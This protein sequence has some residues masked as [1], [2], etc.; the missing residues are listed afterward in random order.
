MTRRLCFKTPTSALSD[1]CLGLGG[2]L[3]YW[4]N[5]LFKYKRHSYGSSC[6]FYLEVHVVIRTQS[7]FAL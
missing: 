2:S 4:N 5:E 1:H 6:R 7:N 3:L